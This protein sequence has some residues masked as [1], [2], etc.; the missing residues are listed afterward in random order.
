MKA[1]CLIVLTA[2]LLLA[3][4]AKDARQKE[5]AKLKGTWKATTLEYNGQNLLGDTIKDLKVAVEGDKMTIKGEG[6]EL[7]KY[8]TAT[9]KIDPGT[10]PKVMDVTIA[11]GSEKGTTFEGIYELK[12]DEWKA[13]VKLG[14]DRPTKLE[15]EAGSNTVLVVFKREKE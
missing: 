1:C 9:L 4:E 10:T 11:A 12:G 3:A 14:K 2:G 6:E 13:C 8:P 5:L 7:K 15:S